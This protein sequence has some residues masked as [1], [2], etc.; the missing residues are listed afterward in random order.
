M[1][2]QPTWQDLLLAS[3]RSK[4]TQGGSRSSQ[5]AVMHSG[6]LG[7]A[8][9]GMLFVCFDTVLVGLSVGRTRNYVGEQIEAGEA[10]TRPQRSRRRKACLSNSTGIG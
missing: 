7:S 8:L 5:F 9:F 2:A 10:P 1:E 4:M 6:T 3:S